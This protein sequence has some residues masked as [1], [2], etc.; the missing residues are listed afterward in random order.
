M[1]SE[2]WFPR[3]LHPSSFQQQSPERPIGVNIGVKKRWLSSVPFSLNKL[4]IYNAAFRAYLEVQAIG[5]R[6]N[7]FKSFHLMIC[8]I[9]LEIEKKTSHAQIVFNYL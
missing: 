8:A 6:C 7:N 3:L 5:V 1:G 2:L 4:E 9:F